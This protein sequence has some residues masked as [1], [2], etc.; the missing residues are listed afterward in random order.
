MLLVDLIVGNR[1]DVFHEGPENKYFRLHKPKSLMS[2]PNSAANADKHKQGKNKCA[3]FNKTV[4][5]KTGTSCIGPQVIAC[6]PLDGDV[7]EIAIYPPAMLAQSF[8]F[9]NYIHGSGSIVLFINN[10]IVI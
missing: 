4:F 2:L 9:Y 6:W 1:W 3:A 8:P 7:D 5:I 10:E